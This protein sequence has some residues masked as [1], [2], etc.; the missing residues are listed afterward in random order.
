MGHVS[1]M[2]KIGLSCPA[3]GHTAG[4]RQ[5]WG[6]N[7]ELRSRGTLGLLAAPTCSLAVSLPFGSPS[8]AQDPERSPLCPLS[9]S[10]SLGS[11]WITANLL[12]QGLGRA[13]GIDVPEPPPKIGGCSPLSASQPP[14]QPRP[15]PH[16]P[17]PPIK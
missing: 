1:Q 5:D 16:P 12:C 15:H 3:G 9:P 6:S 4:S 2:E 7:P 8:G 13:P 17:R 10:P 14:P 11:L